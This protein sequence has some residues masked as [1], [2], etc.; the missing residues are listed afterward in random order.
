MPRAVPSAEARARITSA[1]ELAHAHQ[2]VAGYRY[3]DPAEVNASE[4]FADAAALILYV[5]DTGDEASARAWSDARSLAVLSGV[6]SHATGPACHAAVDAAIALRERQGATGLREALDTAHA[7]SLRYRHP[8]PEELGRLASILSAARPGWQQLDAATLASAVT[9]AAA[10]MA[11]SSSLHLHACAEALGRTAT[12]PGDHARQSAIAEATALEAADIA[13]TSRRLR[14]LGCGGMI[15]DMHARVRA[16]V[17][18]E[19]APVE[20]PRDH[21]GLTRA[22]RAGLARAER[23]WVVVGP[24]APMPSRARIVSAFSDPVPQA[25]TPF[26][27]P[28]PDRMRRLGELAF[29]ESA[30][31]RARGEAAALAETRDEI[32]EIAW[33]LAVETKTRDSLRQR[34]GRD[35][36]DALLRLAKERPRTLPGSAAAILESETL[37]AVLPLLQDAAT[38]WDL[39]LHGRWRRG[40]PGGRRLDWSGRDLRWM[41]LAQTDLEGV[42]L[43]GAAMPDTGR[44]ASRPTLRHA[45]IDGALKL[46]CEDDWAVSCPDGTRRAFVDGSPAL[47]VEFVGE[48]GVPR[49]SGLLPSR[50]WDDT[51][52]RA[53]FGPGARTAQPCDEHFR[54][55]RRAAPSDRNAGTFPVR[56]SRERSGAA[57]GAAPR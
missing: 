20:V 24:G 41:D 28:V 14:A 31:L 47:V 18:D 42:A 15:P 40:E 55:I 56:A 3:G 12:A 23:E 33:T 17:S 22:R 19:S 8:D 44:L 27:I 5:L 32:R 49:C 9:D 35:A 57:A 46:H 29:R 36:A 48:D 11:R 21:P 34:Y 6:G 4:S 50:S 54:A 52:A 45:L 16:D 25:R 10:T 2:W 53:E 51:R 1:H 38:A 26:D 7:I 30:M 39:E 13:D 37:L 43:E